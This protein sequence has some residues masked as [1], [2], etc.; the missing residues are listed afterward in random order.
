MKTTD[1]TTTADAVEYLKLELAQARQQRDT[2]LAALRRISE[3]QFDR[4]ESAALFAQGIARA[5]I[6]AAESEDQ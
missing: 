4:P 6:A 3:E 2:A 5:V 1:N